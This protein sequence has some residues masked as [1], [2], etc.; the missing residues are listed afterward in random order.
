MSLYL[1]YVVRMSSIQEVGLFDEITG[2][3]EMV[4]NN[5]DAL[6]DTDT[7]MLNIFT[8]L[9]VILLMK[10]TSHRYSYKHSIG[11][12]ADWS[13]SWLVTFVLGWSVNHLVLVATISLFLSIPLQ[14][15]KCHSR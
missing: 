14:R 4:S 1:F 2:K 12:S 3:I 11:W 13:V 6:D 15:Q 9:I 7:G 8:A 10:S 5:G